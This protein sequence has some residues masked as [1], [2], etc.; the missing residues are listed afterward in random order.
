[1]CLVHFNRSKFLYI[2]YEVI[3]QQYNSVFYLT[4]AHVSHY[5]AIYYTLILTGTMLSTSCLPLDMTCTAKNI[6]KND[7]IKIKKI[8][9][10][11]NLHVHV[12]MLK[13]SNN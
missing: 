3:L 7:D 11:T 13:V 10:T 2:V 1:M 9:H 4:K 8:R 5:K 6:T 12:A